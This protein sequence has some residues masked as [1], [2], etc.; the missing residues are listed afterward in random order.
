MHRG[1]ND[2]FRHDFDNQYHVDVLSPWI[3]RP[4]KA[5]LISNT[6]VRVI[7]KHVLKQIDAGESL[8]NQRKQAKLFWLS[9]YLR[10]VNEIH[11]PIH[12]G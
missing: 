11:G 5:G 8:E 3:S 1:I 10:Y 9:E 12:F 4:P 2:Y 7:Q 6:V